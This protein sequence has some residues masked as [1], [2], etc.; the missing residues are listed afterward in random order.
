MLNE[1]IPTSDAD[2]RPDPVPS[3]S[4]TIPYISV[5]DLRAIVSRQ[6]HKAPGADGLTAKIVKSAWPAI[7][8]DMYLLTNMCLK[9][10]NFLTHGRMHL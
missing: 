2:T 3:T 6:K 7:E 8:H 5:E 9:K 1:L 4:E 10:K